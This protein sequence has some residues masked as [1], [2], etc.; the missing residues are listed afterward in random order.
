MYYDSTPQ[1]DLMLYTSHEISHQWF[2]Q[3]GGQ[4]SSY[5]TLAG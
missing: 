4:R 2:F 3:P 1:S 5:G